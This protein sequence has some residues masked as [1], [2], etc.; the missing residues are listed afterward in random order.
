MRIKIKEIDEEEEK[1][2]LAI[3][4]RFAGLE[5]GICTDISSVSN[6][7]IEK[8]CRTREVDYTVL[9]YPHDFPIKVN[10]LYVGGF[11]SKKQS[12]KGLKILGV[13]IDEN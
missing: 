7:N 4:S 5:K 1:K 12:L 2:E 6:P 11:I 13:G 3:K 10:A 8:Y 9:R